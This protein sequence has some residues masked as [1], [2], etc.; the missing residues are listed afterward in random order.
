MTFATSPL[1]GAAFNRRTAAPEFKVSAVMPD[2][3]F[4]EIKEDRLT[5]D[6]EKGKALFEVNPPEG[7]VAL[8][9]ECFTER[10]SS[11]FLRA[12]GRGFLSRA[13]TGTTLNH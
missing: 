3:S 8:T 10:S 13:F 1:V 4:K 7:A 5:V 2:K 6:T 12:A 11:K 9:I